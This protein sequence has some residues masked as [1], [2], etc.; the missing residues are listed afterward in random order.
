[1]NKNIQCFENEQ[2]IKENKMVINEIHDILYNHFDFQTP[3]ES[4]NNYLPEMNQDSASQTTNNT[5]EKTNNIQ[6]HED[7]KLLLDNYNIFDD[8]ILDKIFE[9]PEEVLVFNY[10][11]IDEDKL[12]EQDKEESNAEPNQQDN[13]ITTKERANLN[14]EINDKNRR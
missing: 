9:N 3:Y 1:M 11:K 5:D 7:S 8:N 6:N 10:G 14:E 4:H 13:D 2:D 12:E